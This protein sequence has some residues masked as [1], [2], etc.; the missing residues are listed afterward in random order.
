MW[1]WLFGNTD[2]CNRPEILSL[3]AYKSPVEALGS[4][5]GGI[6]IRVY[7]GS[8]V[9]AYDA[10]ETVRHFAR[11]CALDAAHAWE[12]P[13]ITRRYLRTGEASIRLAADLAA[14]DIIYGPGWSIDPSAA[15][16]AKASTLLLTSTDKADRMSSSG[17]ASWYSARSAAQFAF[18]STEGRQAAKTDAY[19]AG[20]AESFVA[21]ERRLGR[22]LTTGRKKVHPVRCDK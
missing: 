20:W 22:M 16:D 15:K 19:G 11:L 6:V 9:W 5:F 12:I 4:Q 1:M 14:K 21:Q 7:N 18:E 10:T 2:T 8:F 3:G 17:Q 13:D